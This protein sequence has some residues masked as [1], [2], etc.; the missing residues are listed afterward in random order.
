LNNNFRSYYSRL[1]MEREADLAGVF[2]TRKL[3]VS[4]HLVP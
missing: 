4:S 3:G 2:K 1:I